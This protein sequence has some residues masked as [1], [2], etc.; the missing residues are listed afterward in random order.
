[1]EI[2]VLI[3]YLFFFFSYQSSDESS[4]SSSS[5]PR[6]VVT[7]TKILPSDCTDLDCCLDH[8][9]RAI[10]GLNIESEEFDARRIGTQEALEEFR[11]KFKVPVLI[12]SFD[13]LRHLICLRK[14]SLL[15]VTNVHHGDIEAITRLLTLETLELGPCSPFTVNRLCNW[16]EYWEKLKNLRLEALMVDVEYSCCTPI[17]DAVARCPIISAVSLINFTLG[18]NFAAVMASCVWLRKFLL[19]PLYEQED[20]DDQYKEIWFGVRRMA[21]NLLDL[22]VGVRAL[23]AA[24]SSPSGDQAPEG[25][26]LQKSLANSLPETKVEIFEIKPEQVFDIQLE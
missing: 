15:N 6:M 18:S 26:S 8:D 5:S 2:K 11:L 16:L 19:V 21:A 10:V 1:M 20:L 3:Q 9:Y 17:L 23:P 14:L 7:R 24:D 13:E 12:K 25:F 22:K 4:S